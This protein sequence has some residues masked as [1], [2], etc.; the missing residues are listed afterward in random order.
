MKRITYTVLLALLVLAGCKP[1]CGKQDVLNT[2]IYTN[3]TEHK[4]E[5]NYFG[6]VGLDN[7]QLAFQLD[8]TTPSFTVKK[9]LEGQNLGV[10]KADSLHVR[11]NDTLSYMFRIDSCY[12]G[13]DERRISPLCGVGW[14]YSSR[15]ECLDNYTNS[16]KVG[17][18]LYEFVERNQ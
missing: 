1:D 10:F 11:F 4:V 5:F 8:G 3:D 18:D 17:T 7:P 16:Y 12:T 6:I 13:L 9:R 15:E 2:Y 14:S